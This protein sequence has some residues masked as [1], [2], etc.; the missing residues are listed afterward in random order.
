MWAATVMPLDDR[1]NDTTVDTNWKEKVAVDWPRCENDIVS[2]PRTS[3]M[4]ISQGKKYGTI[5]RDMEDIQ[6]RKC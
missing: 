5:L 6:Q 4:W 2:L 3:L 1:D